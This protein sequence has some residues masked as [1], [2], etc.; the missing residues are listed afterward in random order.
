MALKIIPIQLESPICCLEYLLC[1]FKS[2]IS[3][4]GTGEEKKILK[5]RYKAAI[6]GGQGGISTHKLLGLSTNATPKLLPKL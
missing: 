1:Y 2:K 4:M 3:G 6:E 5:W